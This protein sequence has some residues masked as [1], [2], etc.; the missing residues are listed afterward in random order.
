MYKV[1]EFFGKP[2][3]LEEYLNKKCV[4]E[5]LSVSQVV[6]PVRNSY[7]IIF[8]DNYDEIEKDQLLQDY[9]KENLCEKCLTCASFGYFCRGTKNGCNEWEEDINAYKRLDKAI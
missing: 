1:E 8:Y 4:I 6:S 5:H 2:K 9:A 3:E 7:T